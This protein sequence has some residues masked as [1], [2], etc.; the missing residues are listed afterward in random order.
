[1]LFHPDGHDP[2]REGV[3]WGTGGLGMRESWFCLQMYLERTLAQ[4]FTSHR[5]MACPDTITTQPP[6]ICAATPQDKSQV[7]PQHFSA[8]APND[9]QKQILQVHTW[10]YHTLVCF[11]TWLVS[12][13]VGVCELLSRYP[14][15]RAG[16]VFIIQAEP[17]PISRSS[18]HQAAHK[19]LL[20]PGNTHIDFR[21]EHY[22]LNTNPVHVAMLVS[23]TCY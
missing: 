22:K 2:V 10:S 12:V 7:H 6:F 5:P 11:C 3:G 15:K 13:P 4:S 16:A 23:S 8:L 21:I 9:K 19:G 17:E 1:M 20:K 18:K 14:A